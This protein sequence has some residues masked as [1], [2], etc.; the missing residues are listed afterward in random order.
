MT[1]RGPVAAAIVRRAQMRA[2]LQHLTRNPDVGLPRVVAIRL[3]ATARVLWYAARLPCIR[4]VLW[5]VPVRRPLPDIA[6]HVVDAIAVGRKCR[7]RRGA[8]V[9]VVI[10]VVERKFTLPGVG[11]VRAAGRELVAPGELGPVEA[12]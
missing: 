4:L 7:H 1:G 6:D 2:A 11:P 8:L 9:S 12:A 3:G 10:V 5:R